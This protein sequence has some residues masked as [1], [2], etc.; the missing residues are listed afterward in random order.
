MVAKAHGKDI[1]ESSRAA[2]DAFLYK[3]KSNRM[4]HGPQDAGERRDVLAVAIHRVLREN[5]AS[6]SI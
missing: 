2:M 6:K 4:K 1:Y 5:E 3:S